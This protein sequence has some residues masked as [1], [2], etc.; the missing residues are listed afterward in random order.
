MR[1]T[2]S[3]IEDWAE[4]NEKESQFSLPLLIRKLILETSTVINLNFPVGDETYRPG[5]DGTVETSAG[6]AWVPIGKSEWE[7]GCNKNPQKKAN[8]DFEKRKAKKD[9]S[10]IF[11]TPRVWLKKDEW[12]KEISEGSN[13]REIKVYDSSDLETWLET[14][15][16][17]RLWFGELLGLS[18]GGIES[19]DKYWDNWRNQTS[20]PITIDAFTL[21]RENS[22]E[23]LLKYIETSQSIINIKADSQEEAVAFVCSQ[24]LEH[25]LANSCVCITNNEGWRFIDKNNEIKVIIATTTEI[26]KQQAPKNGSIL[27]APLNLGTNIENKNNL[28][29]LGRANSEKYQEALKFLG[30]PKLEAE[31]LASSTGRSWTVYR[32]IKAKNSAISSPLWLKDLNINCLTTLVLFGAWDSSNQA[33]IAYL[34]QF[35]G[36]SYQDLEKKLHNI[37]QLDDAPIIR[38]SNVWKDKA[39]IELLYLFITHITLKELEKF[40]AIVKDI[41]QQNDPALELAIDQRGAAAVY[42]KR[43]KESIIFTDSISNT[44][45]KLRVYAESHRELYISIHIINGIDKLISDVLNDADATRWLSLSSFL[46]SLA[47]AAPSKFLEMLEKDLNK[48]KI[49]SAL[50]TESDSSGFGQCYYVALLW[51]LEIL[52]WDIN[53]LTRVANICCQL[54]S[55]KSKGNFGNNPFQTLTSLFYLIPLTSA[56]ISERNI[57]I[58]QISKKHEEIVWR[59]LK[60]LAKELTLPSFH[61]VNEQPRWRDY[62]SNANLVVTPDEV[63]IY[64]GYIKNKLLELAKKNSQRIADLLTVPIMSLFHQEDEA[65]I[66]SLLDDIKNLD[67]DGLINIRSNLRGYLSWHNSYNKVG[68]KGDRYFADVLYPYFDLLAP[69]DIVKKHCWIFESTLINLP[70]GNTKD[71]DYQGQERKIQKI[72]L[73]TLEEIYNKKKWDG[74]EEL[75]SLCKNN[76]ILGRVIKTANLPKGEFYQWLVQYFIKLNLPIDNLLLQN[77]ISWQND[78]L[79]ELL[80]AVH[81]KITDPK[82]FVLFLLNVP[83]NGNAQQFIEALPLAEQEYYWKNIYAD[84]IGF[85]NDIDLQEYVIKKLVSVKRFRTILNILQYQLQNSSSERLLQVVDGISAGH[86]NEIDLNSYAIIEAIKTLGNRDIPISKL[87]SVEFTYFSLLEHNEYGTPH[88]LALIKEQPSYY[89]HFFCLAYKIL[90][91]PSVETSK[92]AY[93]L[94]N[95]SRFIPGLREDDSIGSQFFNSWIEYARDKVKEHTSDEDILR[96]FDQKLGELLSGSPSNL[97]DSWPAETICD[98]LDESGSEEI[99][100]GFCIGVYN[101]RGVHS[102]GFGEGGKQERVLAKKYRDFAQKWQLTHPLTAELLKTIADRYDADAIREDTWDARREEGLSQF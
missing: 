16:S 97:D 98:L 36:Y 95:Q 45:M 78:N 35:C 48:N 46:P 85:L 6:N 102:R 86:E 18:G 63:N 42:D 49:V 76:G 14:A 67:D 13:W 94:I 53:Y 44:L 34:E 64:V 50:F 52:A 10:F 93:R 1:I 31:R 101:N 12:Q 55:F 17:T 84:N 66:K 68:E 92:V 24:L 69:K 58:D 70:E 56:K 26:A 30:E 19:I 88:L 38:I 54:D 51:A 80:D 100:H 91:S 23:Q 82:Q 77:I 41:F 96:L 99:R 15:P 9:T 22:K 39:P 81:K 3:Q 73:S 5:L 79:N 20:L 8:E 25:R 89:I 60:S 11:I 62:C 2:A 21:G 83:C 40:F 75:I 61:I 59:L 87:A 90:S 43:R 74:I 7:I 4:T 32:R 29:N 37:V 33:D 71:Q 47:E 27:I 57:V 65:I 28:V 72:Q